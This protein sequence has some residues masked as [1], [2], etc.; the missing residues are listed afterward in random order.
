LGAPVVLAARRTS[1]IPAAEFAERF[2]SIFAAAPGNI[3]HELFLQMALLVPQ[4]A[5]RLE[6]LKHADNVGE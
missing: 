3:R 5:K 1:V 2:F 6:L 4:A